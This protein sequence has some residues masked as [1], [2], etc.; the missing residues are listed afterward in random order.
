MASIDRM[1]AE[2]EA[3]LA[4]P[5]KSAESFWEQKARC[6]LRGLLAQLKQEKVNAEMSA[7]H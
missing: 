4:L 2:I 1:I 5:M 6:F 3:C 7:G